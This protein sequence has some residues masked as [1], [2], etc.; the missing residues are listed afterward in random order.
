M[1]TGKK[2]KHKRTAG[3]RRYLALK[4]KTDKVRFDL[5]S[6]RAAMQG[7]DEANSQLRQMHIMQ[8]ITEAIERLNTQC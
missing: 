7:A 5:T 3:Q 1:T 4:R 2:R 8:K 6:L